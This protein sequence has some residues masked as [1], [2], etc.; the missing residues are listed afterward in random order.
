M[1]NKS[2]EKQD[3]QK[4]RIALSEKYL[5]GKG[6]EIGALHR[7]LYVSKKA[8]VKYVDRLDMIGLRS[9]YPEL[10]EYELTKIDIL[11]DGEKL[12]T[13]KDCSLDFIIANHMLEHCENP[14]GAIR[15]HLAKLRS[16]GVLYYAVPDKRYTF[17]AERQLTT[18][19]HLVDDDKRK[20]IDKES[21]TGHFLDFIKAVYKDMP[22]AEQKTNAEKFM[23]MN[24]SIHFHVW[25]ASSFRE[26][27]KKSQKY[28]NDSFE[29]IE[30]RENGEEMIAILRK[31][32]THKV[33]KVLRRLYGIFS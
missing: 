20:I 16:K 5:V 11:D 13:I 19:D 30:F 10:N 29:I 6:I 23:Q 17:D 25:N 24:Y 4:I 3:I 31:R 1:E 32:R 7:P 28:F 22:S 15:N 14:L 27:L 21:R 26:F 33:K 8:H 9:H 2:I 18:F 12:L